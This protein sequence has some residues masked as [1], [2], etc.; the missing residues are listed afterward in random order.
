MEIKLEDKEN[1]KWPQSQ[2]Y[3]TQQ[4]MNCRH[5]NKPDNEIT[6]QDYVDKNASCSLC[7]STAT[8]FDSNTGEIICSI[9][10]MVIHDYMESLEPEW[11]S[12]SDRGMVEIS[13]KIRT[14]RPI[15]LALYDKGLSTHISYSNVDANGDTINPIQT[16]IVERIRRW[17]KI[18]RFSNNSSA[19]NLKYAFEVMSRIKDKLSLT[20]AVIEKAAYFYL[21]LL[22]KN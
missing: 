12:F 8:I 17:D 5:K 4:N 21:E 20:D 7:K 1:S 9:C 15:S 18:S 19:R 13:K 22:L 3:K 11:R 10:G 2:K 14:G 6:Y 16:P